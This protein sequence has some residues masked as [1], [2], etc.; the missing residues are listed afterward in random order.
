MLR[1]GE[2]K[3][4]G[5]T[6]R[7][8]LF[9]GSPSYSGEFCA[10]YV[11]S[12]LKTCQLLK[13]KDIPYEV[14]FALYDSLTARARNDIVDIFLKTDATHILM[15]DGDQG[16]P[17][18]AVL[19]LLDFKK[20]FITGAVP[21]RKPQEEY[22]FKIFVHPDKTPIVYERS[23]LRCETNGVAF[24]LIKREVFEK[25]KSLRPYKQPV[26]PFFQ[27]YYSVVGDHYGE[28]AF[29]VKTWRDIGGE[30]WMYPD[31]TFEHGPIKANYHEY[32]CRQ[33]KPKYIDRSIEAIR[34]LINKTEVKSE[35]RIP[36][37]A[38]S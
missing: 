6:P 30:V 9:I 36:E 2:K 23:L 24:A 19:Q 18:M 16:W 34:N 38:V 4:G 29:F 5:A 7:Y 21:N 8:S 12:L 35:A 17:A 10:I 28:D 14:Y 37:N 1:I 33:P 15:V 26:Y 31:I 11:S 25:I 3:P 22:A 20:E 32:L 13:E 27:H